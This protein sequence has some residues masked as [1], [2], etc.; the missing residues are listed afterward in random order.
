MLFCLDIFVLAAIAIFILY[1][2]YRWMPA[3]MAESKM[4]SLLAGLA[5]GFLGSVVSIWWDVGPKVGHISPLLSVAGALL[6]IVL[7][8]LVPFFK[9]LLMPDRL[10]KRR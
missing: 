7:F 1:L 5:G 6:F 2:G 8:G 9:I 10:P 3:V 4:R